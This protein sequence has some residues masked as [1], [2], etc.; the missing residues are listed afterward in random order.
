MERATV[1]SCKAKYVR[2]YC[3]PY[4]YQSAYLDYKRGYNLVICKKVIVGAGVTL[5]F[6][7]F[8]YINC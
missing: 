5:Q 8:Q 4:C 2:H 1:N 6:I 3:Q 7:Q